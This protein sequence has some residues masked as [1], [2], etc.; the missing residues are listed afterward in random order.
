MSKLNR[1]NFLTAFGSVSAGLALSRSSTAQTR[2][3]LPE[4]VND[5]ER[6]KKLITASRERIRQKFFPNIELTTHEG[7]KVKLYDD[8]VKDKII[9]L[10]FM[11]ATCDGI[12]PGITRNL[13]KAQKMLGDI[14]GSDVFMYSVT[15]K[16]KEDTVQVLNTHAKAM[17][18]KPGWLFL[19]GS[20][21][22][23]ELLRRS[24][25]FVDPDP[26]RDKDKNNH[27]GNVRFG[28]EKMQ[29][30]GSCPGLGKPELIVESLLWLD[31]K[32]KERYMSQKDNMKNM[33]DEHDMHD[34]HQHKHKTSSLI[35]NDRGTTS[36]GGK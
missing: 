8:L 6:T 23:I 21:E 26:I 12:C 1:R 30:W 36:G 5:D 7:K 2:T 25:G 14:V 20:E 33:E 16:P 28:N 29:Y 3:E 4:L 31:P 22:D 24:Q 15:L 18:A 9:T 10:N 34:G 19:T 13:A 35:E 27:T 32:I 11:Y 17:N